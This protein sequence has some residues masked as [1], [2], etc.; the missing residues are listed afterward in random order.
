MS[1]PQW[2]QPLMFLVGIATGMIGGALLSLQAPIYW[3]SF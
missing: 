1:N 3:L 2:M